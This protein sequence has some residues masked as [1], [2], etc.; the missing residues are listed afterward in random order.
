VAVAFCFGQTKEHFKEVFTKLHI[1]CYAYEQFDQCIYDAF[2]S[3]K[4][5]KKILLFSP[6]CASFDLFHN[7][8]ERAGAFMKIISTL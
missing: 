5:D 7:R 3:C 4:K 8:E 1:P 6:G 2:S